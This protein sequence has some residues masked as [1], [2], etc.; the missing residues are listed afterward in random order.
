LSPRWSKSEKRPKR[1]GPKDFRRLPETEREVVFFAEGGS[2]APHLVPIAEELVARGVPVA[3]LTSDAGDPT[4][5]LESD[6]LRVFDVG[7][8][9]KRSF[10]MQNLEA[11]VVVSTTPRLGTI[12]LPRSVN[13]SSYGTQYV[14][15]F[16]S[17][18]STHMIYD[19]DAFDGYDVMFCVGSFMVDE[20]RTREQQAGLRAKRLFEHGFT[21]LDSIRARKSASSIR[22]EDDLVV[23]APSWG[24]TCIIESCGSAVVR[25]LRDAEMRV[26][27]RP[28]PMTT[29][30]SPAAV[31]R[32]AAEFATDGGVVFETDVT[33]QDSLERAGMMVSDWSGAALEYAF[34]DDRPVLFVDVPRKVNNHGYEALGI[35]PFE[36]SVRARIGAVCAPDRLDRLAELVTRTQAARED[37]AA[38]IAEVRRQSVYNVDRSIAAA[39]EEIVAMTSR[40]SEHSG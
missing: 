22:R 18:V 14:H 7:T 32:L 17:M 1:A 27:V 2:Y 13:A 8:G 11:R 39:A 15:V 21:R 26:I 6:R 28:H 38:E 37:R 35:T 29:S 40:S 30:R 31:E 3:Y 9:T 4:F 25:A 19:A 23:V 16:H 34:A 36:V 10:L 33:S 20:I 12:H 24:P 5:D